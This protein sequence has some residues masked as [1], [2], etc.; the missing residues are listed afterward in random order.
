[1]EVKKKKK[2][3][4]EIYKKKTNTLERSL[5]WINQVAN[6]WLHGDIKQKNTHM[7]G[8]PIILCFN[9]FNF[10]ISFFVLNYR[11]HRKRPRERNDSKE[12]KK[13]TRFSKKTKLADI[14]EFDSGL[15]P[16]NKKKK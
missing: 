5:I 15:E 4:D 12:D 11:V 2:K 3:D 10:L 14:S 16:I 13:F 9:F 7:L 6:L 1:M 8:G